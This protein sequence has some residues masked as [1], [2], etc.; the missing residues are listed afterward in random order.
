MSS[1]RNPRLLLTEDQELFI[2]QFM[3]QNSHLL[4]PRLRLVPEQLNAGGLHRRADAVQGNGFTP[5]PSTLSS[6][7]SSLA[8]SASL[9]P[10]SALSSSTS[11]LER[12]EREVERRERALESFGSEGLAS[13]LRVSR[14][15]RGSLS[16]ED[17]AEGSAATLASEDGANDLAPPLTDGLRLS[18]FVSENDVDPIPLLYPL[19]GA[20]QTERYPDDSQTLVD[21]DFTDKWFQDQAEVF[22]TS[23]EDWLA[24]QVE[25]R[26]SNSC[27]SLA[28][29]RTRSDSGLSSNSPGNSNEEDGDG[30]VGGTENVEENNLDGSLVEENGG[31]G[32]GRGGGADP[33]RPAHAC[34]HNGRSVR[35]SKRRSTGHHALRDDDDDDDDEEEEEEEEEEDIQEEEVNSF[36]DT[37]G[38]EDSESTHSGWQVSPTPASSSKEVRNAATS[39]LLEITMGEGMWIESP[40]CVPWIDRLLQAVKGKPWEDGES[41]ETV[42]LSNLTRLLRLAETADVGVTFVHMMME[43][44]FAA[45]INSVLHHERLSLIEVGE[46][47][48]ASLKPI[49]G[50]LMKDQNVTLYSLLSWYSAGSRWG[51]LAAGGTVYLLMIIASKPGL[52]AKLKGRTVTSTTI[53][54]L[55]NILR[56]PSTSYLQ[57]LIRLNLVPFLERVAQ[58][59]K[60]FNIPKMLDCRNLEENDNYFERFF[61]RT[62]TPLPRLSSFWKALLEASA[63]P[64]GTCFSL[65]HMTRSYLSSSLKDSDSEDERLYVSVKTQSLPIFVGN[66]ASTEEYEIE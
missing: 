52:A 40:G 12:R 36:P 14:S 56:F 23:V 37:P 1:S 16:G 17:L 33:G 65:H 64:E 44:L 59:R 31:G 61:Q 38:G 24:D 53:V 13:S 51:R 42:N 18:G 46:V 21:S 47:E 34:A 20:K 2:L 54:D 45:K 32:G 26:S 41:L 55:T 27:E 63:E 66:Y 7:S 30:D 39:L 58:F 28:R 43:L 15:A 35:A 57:D 3:T 60:Y 48:K 11:N 50:R 8:S 4:P 29:K 25:E 9:A 10:S 19:S 62:A 5:F 49:L 22:S 6:S